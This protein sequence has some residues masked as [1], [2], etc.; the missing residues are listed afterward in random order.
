MGIQEERCKETQFEGSL[1]EI[2]NPPQQ[3]KRRN[4]KGS[5][6]AAGELLWLVVDEVIVWDMKLLI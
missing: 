1:P 3:L 4:Q 5:R 2:V 6:R